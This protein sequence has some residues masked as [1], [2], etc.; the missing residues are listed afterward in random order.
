MGHLDDWK[1][2]ESELEKLVIDTLDQ[3]GELYNSE[4]KFIKEQDSFGDAGRVDIL[5]VAEGYLAVIELK[6]E[7]ASSAEVAQLLRYLG[8]AIENHWELKEKYPVATQPYPW[9]IL[10]AP[11][12]TSDAINVVR[13]VNGCAEGPVDINLVTYVAMRHPETDAKGI[14]YEDRTP[15]YLP[16]PPPPSTHQ[17]VSRCKDEGVR[18]AIDKV[19]DELRHAGCDYRGVGKRTIEVTFGESEDK[20]IVYLQ[21]QRNQF[22]CRWWD[23]PNQ[24]GGD[25]LEHSY[26]AFTSFDEW[27]KRCW[28]SIA[29]SIEWLKQH[30]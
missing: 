2:T 12:F 4:F 10:I 29:G 23:P 26:E 19:I 11:S 28:H 1:P 18:Q 17:I 30:P 27:S 14:H 16:P 25:W 5:A 3:L 20:Y 8:W 22:K 21:V 7:T 24:A 9:G 13:A 6:N 15:D